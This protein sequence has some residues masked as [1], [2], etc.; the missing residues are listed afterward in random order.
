MTRPPP[1]TEPPLSLDTLTK[2]QIENDAIKECMSG[3]DPSRTLEY[4]YQTAQLPPENLGQFHIDETIQ[5]SSE[6]AGRAS[7]FL[8]GVPPSAVHIESEVDGLMISGDI[9]GVCGDKH[10]YIKPAT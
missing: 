6:I 4:L 1:E 3:S 8:G 9:E 2:Y 7:D 5:K 10:T